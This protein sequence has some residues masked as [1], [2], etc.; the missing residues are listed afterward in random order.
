MSLTLAGRRLILSYP[1]LQTP[2][3]PP[4]LQCLHDL[5]FLH[6]LHVLLPIHF[7]ALVDLFEQQFFSVARE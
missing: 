4:A 7:D 6:A 5:Q 2:Q 1:F 3:L